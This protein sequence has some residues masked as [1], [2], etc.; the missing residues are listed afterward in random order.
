MN[1]QNFHGF[2]RI[3]QY[4]GGKDSGNA[5]VYEG[6]FINGLPQGMGQKVL[7]NGSV[8]LG[9]FRFGLENGQGEMIFSEAGLDEVEKKEIHQKG[10]FHFGIYDKEIN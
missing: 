10:N 6:W 2:G 9:E 5:Y 8:Y 3:L 7:Q 4:I 1:T